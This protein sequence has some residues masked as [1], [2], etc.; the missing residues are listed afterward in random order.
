MISILRRIKKVLRYASSGQPISGIISCGLVG[1]ATPLSV[2]SKRSLLGTMVPDVLRITPSRLRGMGLLINPHDWSQTIIYDEIFVSNGYDF[3]LIGFEPQHVVDCGGHIGM[4]SL[5]ATATFPKA[6]VT[7]FEPNPDNFARIR[8]HCS[9]N[10][11][12]WDCRLGAV[13][14]KAGE[15]HLDIINS[16]YAVF[17]AERGVRTKVFELAA[18][19]KGLAATSLVLKIDVEGEERSMWGEL[20]PILPAQTVVFFE[21]HHGSDGW[22]DAEKQFASNGFKAC[23]L[24]ERGQFYDG[25]AKR[26]T[27]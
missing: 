11:L 21:T 4:F 2:T 1:L 3:S 16:H 6:R 13:G 9:I 17:S 26:I 23:K 12:D 5:L 18:F 22:S 19:I 20:I 8:E 25:Y 7:V 24:V 14:A 15:T 27:V 10:G